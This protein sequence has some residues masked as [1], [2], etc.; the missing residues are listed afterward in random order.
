MRQIFRSAV[1]AAA[2]LGAVAVSAPS[3]ALAWYRG[4]VFVGI[5]PF[6]V[7]VGPPVVYA[8]PPYYA[9]PPPPVA[10]TPVPPGRSCYTATFACPLSPSIAPGTNCS[11]PMSGG[12]VAGGRAG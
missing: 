6:P 10:Y 5:S 9:Y 2:A 11:C 8:P 12:G 4:G 7:I 3:P 1:L